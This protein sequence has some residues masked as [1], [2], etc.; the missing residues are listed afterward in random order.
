MKSHLIV[1]RFH[2]NLCIKKGKQFIGALNVTKFS[3]AFVFTNERPHF[4]LALFS[5]LVSRFASFFQGT[6]MS[7]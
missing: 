7:P 3:P 1:L 6:T 5:N 2:L 4:S